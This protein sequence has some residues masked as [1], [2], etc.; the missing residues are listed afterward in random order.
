MIKTGYHVS[1]Q[2]MRTGSDNTYT[3]Y[4][5]IY[6]AQKRVTV[7]GI[8]IWIENIKGFGSAGSALEFIYEIQK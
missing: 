1:Q 4:E 7:L 2:K 5:H 8:P 6:W 3:Y